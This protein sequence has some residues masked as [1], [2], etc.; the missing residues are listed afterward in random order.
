[1]SEL[2]TSQATKLT[3]NNLAQPVDAQEGSAQGG[4]GAASDEVKPAEPSLWG[5]S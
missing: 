4:T 2:I 3:S 5:K 1:M